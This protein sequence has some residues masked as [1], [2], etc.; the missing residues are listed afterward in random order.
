M[1][2]MSEKT[3]VGSTNMYRLINEGEKMVK[4]AA[5]TPKH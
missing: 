4:A 2:K 3:P 1:L 5:T